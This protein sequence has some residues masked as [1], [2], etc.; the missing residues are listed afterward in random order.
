[1]PQ[2]QEVTMIRFKIVALSLV[3]ISTNT[4]AQY[5]VN[6]G[7]GAVF[8]CKDSSYTANSSSVIYSPTAIGTSIFSLPNVNWRNQYKNGWNINAALGS[9]FGMH[10]NSEIEFLYQRFNRKITGSY[11]WEERFT[12]GTLYAQDYSNLIL[13]ISS[14]TNLYSTFINGSYNFNP[15]RK[16]LPILGL[17]AGIAWINSPSTTADAILTA[18]DPSTPLFETAP[19]LQRSPSLSGAAFAFQLKAGIGYDWS[20][21]TTIL[22][23]RLFATTKFKASQSSFTTNSAES[24]AA[25]TFYVPGQ[26]INGIIT[27]ALEIVFQFK[28]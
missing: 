3:L 26:Y 21:L 22:Q 25:S 19:I 10:W 27:N 14:N 12:N 5:Y 11:G 23:Y 18:D 9:T 15:W 20:R 13:P 24:G 17:G 2:A 7:G 1:M 8:P 28:V 4:Y 6:V 16:L